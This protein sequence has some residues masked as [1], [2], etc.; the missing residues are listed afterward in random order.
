MLKKCLD[1]AMSALLSL[2]CAALLVMVL[3]TAADVG[4]RSF[5]NRPITSSY[6]LSEI[7]MGIFSPIALLYCAYTNSHVCVDI[8]FDHLSRTA[9]RACLLFADAVTLISAFLLAWLSWHLMLELRD[10]GFTTPTLGI[11]SWPL[12][13]VFLLSFILFIPVSMLHMRRGGKS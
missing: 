2:A 11:P 10:F 9:Q 12:G 4:L 1:L 7:L 6:E 8:L 5:F 3:L 13:C